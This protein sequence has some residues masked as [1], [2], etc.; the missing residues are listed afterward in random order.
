MKNSFISTKSSGFSLI[1]LLVVVAILGIISAVGIVSYS[2][3]VEGAK[4][5]SVENVLQQISLGQTEY[6]SDYGYYYR[7]S[8]STRCNATTATSSGIETNLLG[9]SDNITPELGYEICIANHASNYQICAKE[10]GGASTEI[11]L[12]A[13]NEKKT[14]CN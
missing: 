1:E 14:K 10:I 13:S 5:K 4:K 7:N 12:T 6:Y 9:G 8:T 3:Y 2:G 11:V